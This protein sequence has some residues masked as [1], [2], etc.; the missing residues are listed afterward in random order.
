M[1]L[2]MSELV[3]LVNSDE[4]M[5][6]IANNSKM[7]GKSMLRDLY[8]SFRYSQGSTI[9]QN[10]LYKGMRCTYEMRLG[11]AGFDKLQAMLATNVGLDVDKLHVPTAHINST[12][13]K[14]SNPVF[15]EEL[16]HFLNVLEG[17]AII[18]SLAVFRRI[19]FY[20]IGR[21]VQ[22]QKQE[23]AHSPNDAHK[24]YYREHIL[25]LE[26]TGTETFDILFGLVSA[27]LNTEEFTSF[28]RDE[29]L[30]L[31]DS[32]HENHPEDVFLSV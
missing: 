11:E 27:S 22:Y 24:S 16:V 29:I 2:F 18:D 23:R 25:G 21:D 31:I 6:S 28:K 10:D 15:T 32:W 14:G 9:F 7:L 20:T 1:I 19:G 13:M 8:A 3:T 5:L 4:N 30:D 12:K 26:P 17:P